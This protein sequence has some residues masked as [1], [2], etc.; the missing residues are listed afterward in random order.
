MPALNGNFRTTTNAAGH[1][2]SAMQQQL[3]QHSQQLHA[4]SRSP[5]PTA[6]SDITAAPSALPPLAPSASSA[7]SPLP[8]Q[9]P[10][11]YTP[12]R[13]QQQP[14]QQQTE[15]LPQGLQAIESIS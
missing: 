6:G 3:N 11:Q 15:P 14:Q 4:P 1:N 10:V 13:Q 8:S 2:E 7:S 12:Q 5:A 9:P